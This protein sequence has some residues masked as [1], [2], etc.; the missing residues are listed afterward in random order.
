MEPEHWISLG[1]LVVAA[2]SVV[3]SA[4]LAPQMAARLAQS[5]RIRDERSEAYSEGLRL[6]RARMRELEHAAYGWPSDH[7]GPDDEEAARIT[8]RLLLC[9]S[10]PVWEAFQ[11]F[12]RGYWSTSLDQLSADAARTREQDDIAARLRIGRVHDELEHLMDE[13]TDRMRADLGTGR[14]MMALR[15]ARVRPPKEPPE[16][17]TTP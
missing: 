9:A 5:G 11:A 16:A 1:A 6:L 17:P 8:S 12:F 14:V 7:R 4:W 3:M 10:G 2:V 15:Q 13:T